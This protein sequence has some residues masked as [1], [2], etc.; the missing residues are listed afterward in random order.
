MVKNNDKIKVFGR[1]RMMLTEFQK[2][3]KV[4]HQFIQKD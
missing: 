4:A 2:P 1:F 3:A